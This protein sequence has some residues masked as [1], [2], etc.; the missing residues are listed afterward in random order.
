MCRNLGV[1]L[2]AMQSALITWNLTH[3]SISLN[4]TTTHTTEKTCNGGVDTHSD[5]SSFDLGGG[6]EEDGTLRRRLN[7]GLN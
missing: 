1:E 6:E 5:R 3:S 2:I 7:P 4:N